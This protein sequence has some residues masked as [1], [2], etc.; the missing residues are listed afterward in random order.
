MKTLK[1]V[2]TGK[3]TKYNNEVKPWDRDDVLSAAACRLVR[4]EREHKY[5]YVTISREHMSSEIYH[6]L[7]GLTEHTG[8]YRH[9]EILD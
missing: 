7:N 1:C 2:E 3:K 5:D 9:F 6:A 8:E 4:R